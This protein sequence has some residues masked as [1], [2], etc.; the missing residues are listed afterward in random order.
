M[1]IKS[2]DLSI[3]S[4]VSVFDQRKGCVFFWNRLWSGRFLQ[5]TLHLRMLRL[6]WLLVWQVGEGLLEL[7]EA[8]QEVNA[9]E[10]VWL[11]CSENSETTAA[12]KKAHSSK[13]CGGRGVATSTCNR[14]ISIA[15]LLALLTHAR[16]FRG[17]VNVCG[18]II[19][20]NNVECSHAPP[21]DFDGR[22]WFANIDNRCGWLLEC[23]LQNYGQYKCTGGRRLP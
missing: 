15:T 23:G 20:G 5:R 1:Q 2:T 18:F 4:A 9:Q 17:I 14:L 3:S 13:K 10:E 22:K 8:R 21:V 16:Y 6:H 7:G 12:G 19:F 11:W